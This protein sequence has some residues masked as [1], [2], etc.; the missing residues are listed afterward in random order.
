[1]PQDRQACEA[2]RQQQFLELL[3]PFY[4]RALAYS[5]TLCGSLIDGE[6]L[7]SDAVLRAYAGFHQLRDTSRFKEWFF[8]ILLN[9]FRNLRSRTL[10]RPTT[11]MGDAAGTSVF[12][13][14]TAR[15]S[16]DP[17]ELGYQLTLVQ[18]LLRRLLPAE[19]EVLLLL[20]PCGFS[21]GEVAAMQQC[22]ERAVIQKA[23]RARKKLEKLV[24]DGAL[25]FLT[26]YTEAGNE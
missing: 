11:L 26:K 1:M 17:A 3:M 2:E 9:R 10:L 6:D 7:L 25:P 19:R 16:G 21:P 18:E 22:S 23:Y 8:S 15:V 4:P 5:Q 20:G 24:P 12:W 13:E 14:A